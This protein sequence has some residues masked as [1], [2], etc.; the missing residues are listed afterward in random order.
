MPR[1]LFISIFYCLKGQKGSDSL[2]SA[3]GSAFYAVSILQMPL[4]Q[5]CTMGKEFLG[6]RDFFLQYHEWPLLEN[7]SFSLN[8]SMPPHN[9]STG[10]TEEV[11]MH[12]LPSQ[13]NF[14]ESGPQTLST[15]IQLIIYC[16][17]QDS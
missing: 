11:N 16:Q 14:S 8:T 3:G 4:L 6:C 13:C 17:H 7:V 10:A 5:R 1:G 12:K 2:K 15:K 9:I